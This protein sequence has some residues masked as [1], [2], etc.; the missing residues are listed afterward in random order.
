MKWFC[1]L[2][3]KTFIWGIPDNCYWFWQFFNPF[4]LLVLHYHWLDIW[5]QISKLYF[6][7]TLIDLIKNDFV[8]CVAI[9]IFRDCQKIPNIEKSLHSN[10]HTFIHTGFIYSTKSRY[11]KVSTPGGKL[12]WKNINPEPAFKSRKWNRQKFLKSDNL[13]SSQ[14]SNSFFSNNIDCK[15]FLNVSICSFQVLLDCLSEIF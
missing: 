3:W 15:S 7:E 5:V 8:H 10:S 1:S 11:R 9:L 13:D 4:Q 6:F 12:G 14:F 2:H